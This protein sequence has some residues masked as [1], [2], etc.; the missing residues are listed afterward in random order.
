MKGLEQLRRA[1]ARGVLLQ[2]EAAYQLHLV[3]IWYENKSGEALD[4]LADLRARVP[5]QPALP[6]E[7][8]T[9][10]RGVQERPARGPRRVPFARRRSAARLASRT[11]ARGDVGP[12]RRGGTVC[13]A[14]RARPR[15]RRAAGGHRAA[16][17]GAVRRGGPGAT[18]P[19]ARAGPDRLPRPGG[20]GVPRGSGGGAGRR[21]ARGARGPRI[22]ACRGRPIASR[23]S[24][25]AF[26]S[27]AGARSNAAMRTARARPSTARC[28]S[29]RTM[30]CIGTA[31]AAS[32]RR[33]R[34]SRARSPTSSARCRCAR[35][36]RRP[37]SPR[38]ITSWARSSR[39]RSDRA[40]AAR[41]VRRRAARARR[42]RRDA[43]PCAARSRA[44][45]LTSSHRRASAARV[46]MITTGTGCS[47]GN[48][49]DAQFSA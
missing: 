42:V 24:P 47:A 20:G 13:R 45:S 14:G 19:W 46:N 44:S 25:R 16:A 43:E 7:R 22:L 4:L 38:V 41:H 8:G 35:C 23:P 31:G 34:T 36:R 32:S 15:H 37:S 39:P 10:A 27:R 30:A 11:A 12:P 17:G 29:G 49:I 5:A 18:R 3:D 2:A 21:S 28:S 9:G 33:R 6:A 48:R 1:R 26:R 40:R